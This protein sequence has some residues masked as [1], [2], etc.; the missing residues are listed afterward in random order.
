MPFVAK[1]MNFRVFRV[2]TVNNWYKT[3]SIINITNIVS[4][5]NLKDETWVDIV[6]FQYTFTVM[7]VLNL[8][9]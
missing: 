9:K 1:C 5:A 6:L 8:N 4:N 7:W 3:I 2:I